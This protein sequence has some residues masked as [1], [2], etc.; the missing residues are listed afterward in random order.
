VDRIQSVP[1]RAP[2]VAVAPSSIGYAKGR[3]GPSTRHFRSGITATVAG[4][5]ESRESPVQ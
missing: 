4:G 3:P 1:H 2:V 5:G